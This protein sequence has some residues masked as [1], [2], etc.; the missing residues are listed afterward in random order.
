VRAYL[1]REGE[2][3]LLEAV[4]GLQARAEWQGLVQAFGQDAVQAIIADAFRVL[5]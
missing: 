2:M 1:V 3:D 5:Q 4:D